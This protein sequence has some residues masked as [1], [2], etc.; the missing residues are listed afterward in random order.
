MNTNHHSAP[1][2]K[3]E[4]SQATNRLF[5]EIDDACLKLASGVARGLNRIGLHKL[6]EQA[7]LPD[8]KDDRA[9]ENSRDWWRR[10][11]VRFCR[12]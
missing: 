2:W 1:S 11:G 6:A 12:G 5:S 4:L 7:P 3:A 10:L 9:P 8:R